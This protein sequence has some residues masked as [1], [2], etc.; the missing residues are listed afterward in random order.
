[1]SHRIKQATFLMS[2][3]SYTKCPDGDR[4]EYAF[5]GRSNVGKSSLINRICSKKDLAKTSAKPWKTQLINYFSIESTDETGTIQSRYL[6]DLPGYGYAKSGID[7]RL[8]W[9][10]M[11]VDYLERRETL[12]E[13]FVLIDSRH[14]PQAI[15]LAFINRL[16]EA[17][18]PFSLV[19]TKS[20]LVT[21]KE[22]NKNLKA[23]MTELSKKRETLPLH[24]V[25]N[26][27]KPWS[28]DK[29]VER[30]HEVNETM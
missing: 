26:A 19:F 7:K 29:L 3:P 2:A 10:Q 23:H 13:I 1:M 12:L 30:I 5:I 27:L 4:P 21:Q 16:W 25:T 20:D 9:E 24:F 15:D 14:A 6:V 22:L 18:L 28:T 11:I 8:A 17:W